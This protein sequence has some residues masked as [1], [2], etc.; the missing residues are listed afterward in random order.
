MVVRCVKASISGASLN[1]INNDLQEYLKVGADYNVYGIRV[2]KE[3]NYFMIFDDG[4]LIEVPSQMFEIIEGK[5]SPFWV[6][7][8]S[9][10]KGTTFWPELFYEDDFFENFSEWEEKE[11]KSF[12]ELMQLFEDHKKTSN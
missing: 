9:E 4:H 7:D 6:V 1:I 11:R 2:S 5:A 10:S 12:T 8:Y 3:S